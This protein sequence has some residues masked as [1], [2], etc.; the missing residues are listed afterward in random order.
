MTLISPS[1]WFKTDSATRAH[2]CLATFICPTCDYVRS[3]MAQISAIDA[4]GKVTPALG[5][6]RCGF[7]DDIQLV[8]WTP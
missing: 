1:N 3:I 8:G 7:D 6:C 5:A 2:G 4:Q